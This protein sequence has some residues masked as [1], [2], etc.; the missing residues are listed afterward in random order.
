MFCIA[1]KWKTDVNE[2]AKTHAFYNMI[3]EFNHNELCAYQSKNNNFHIIF[4]NDA[5]D[6][7]RIKDRIEAFKKL[8]KPYNI[9]MTEIAITGNDL[10]ARLMTG[11]WMGLFFSYYLAL[12]YGIDPTPVE[13][14]EKLKKELAK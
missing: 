12:E 10:L 5:K 13:I 8:V 6:H 7:P 4:L 14:I 3:P 2:N 9:P 11:I 1:E